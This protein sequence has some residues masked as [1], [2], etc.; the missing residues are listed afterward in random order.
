[1]NTD[2]LNMM[3]GKPQFNKPKK[4]GMICEHYDYK[5]HLKENYHKIVG[6]PTNFKSKKKTHVV[7]G[8]KTFANNASIEETNNSESQPQGHYLTEEKYKQLV[9]L[10]N[11]PTGAE[12]STNMTG[13]LQWQV[14]GNW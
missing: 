2:P 6:Y 1:M 13:I 4:I 12:R 8:N 3:T 7:G 11:K 10:L 9:G 5:G 14:I